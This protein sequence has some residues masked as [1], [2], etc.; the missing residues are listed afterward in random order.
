M[1]TSTPLKMDARHMRR[2]MVRADMSFPPWNAGPADVPPNVRL[3]LWC[4]PSYEMG[5]ASMPTRR[6]TRALVPPRLQSG[7]HR[8]SALHV[9][10]A[11]THGQPSRA[12]GPDPAPTGRV[13]VDVDLG[14]VRQRGAA[15]RAVP[16]PRRH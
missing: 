10:V 8:N 6:P 3:P 16:A 13:G 1:A 4:S 11:V 15:P 2:I 14:H 9:D 12:G 7:V 5:A